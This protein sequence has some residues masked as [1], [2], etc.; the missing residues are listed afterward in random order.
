[1]KLFDIIK[2][3]LFFGLGVIFGSIVGT[4]VTYTIMCALY[5]MPNTAKILELQECIEERISDR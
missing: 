2:K 1:M 4:L 5:G 3:Y